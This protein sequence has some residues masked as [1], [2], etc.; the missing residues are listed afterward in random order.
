MSF[1]TYIKTGA[2]VGLVSGFAASAYFGGAAKT[3]ERDSNPGTF[4]AMILS[5]GSAICGAPIGATVATG[6]YGLKRSV[7]YLRAA[8]RSIQAVTGALFAT[9]ALVTA[10]YELGNK[11][12]Q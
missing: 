2:G 4:G 3:M 7:Q 1:S 10:A 8:P 5:G 12:H 11:K 9:S 6:F